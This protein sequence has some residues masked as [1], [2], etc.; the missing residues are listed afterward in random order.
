LFFSDR[1]IVHSTANKIA[2][3]NFLFCFLTFKK[4]NAR[5]KFGLEKNSHFLAKFLWDDMA[6][7]WE[8]GKKRKS[9]LVEIA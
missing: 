7:E 5:S 8:L 9:C 1:F 6:K 2:H 3:D 4:S